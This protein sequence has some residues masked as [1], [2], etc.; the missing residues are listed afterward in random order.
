MAVKKRVVLAAAA[1]AALAL[2][3]C[4]QIASGTVH[5]R[6]YSPGYSYTSTTCSK[7]GK[8]TICMPYTQ[9]QPALWELDLY[10]SADT[11]GW[12]SV[13]QHEYDS[14]NIGDQYPACA[15]GGGR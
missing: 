14:C 6:Q 12:R 13:D 5:N 11:H 1:L 2:T 15:T 10:Q 3:G 7:S 8:S 9:Y 4:T